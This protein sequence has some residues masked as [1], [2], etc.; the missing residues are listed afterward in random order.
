ML[1]EAEQNGCEDIISWLPCGTMFKVHNIKK[2]SELVLPS[3]FRRGRYKSFLRQL[4]LY[5]FHRVTTGGDEDQRRGAYTNPW[6]RRNQEDML[7]MVRRASKD[8]SS[9]QSKTRKIRNEQETATQKKSSSTIQRNSDE[10]FDTSMMDYVPTYLFDPL[11]LGAQ[12]YSSSLDILEEII[13]TFGS[14][15]EED[16]PS[17]AEELL[18]DMSSAVVVFASGRA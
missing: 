15:A 10:C 3:Y 7:G 12:Q 9:H 18:L 6:F 1:N 17:T 11:P 8:V 14:Q 2:F 5:K 13:R 16:P 4:N